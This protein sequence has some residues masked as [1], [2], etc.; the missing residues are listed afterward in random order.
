[1]QGLLWTVPLQ[2]NLEPEQCRQQETNAALIYGKASV[3]HRLQSLPT[4]ARDICLQCSS[5]S[6]TQLNK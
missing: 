3:V 1:M 4:H 2:R 6:T 5:L